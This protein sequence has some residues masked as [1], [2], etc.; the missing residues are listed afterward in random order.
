MVAL[1]CQFS[2]LSSGPEARLR[3]ASRLSRHPSPRSAARASAGEVL[4]EVLTTS[5]RSKLD[6]SDDRRFYDVPR[7]CTHVDDA[8]ISQV[9]ELYRQR[10]PAGASVLDLGASHLSHLPE[11]VEYAVV[12]H[13]MNAQELS[14]NR[15]LSSFFVRNLNEAPRGWALADCSLD[16]VV[17]CVSVQYFQRPEEV[18]AEFWRVLKPGGI[19][20]FTFSNRMFST[21]AIATWRDGT[22][23]SRAQLVKSYFGCVAGFTQPEVLTEVS[24]RP[25]DSVLGKLKRLFARSSSD[26]FYAV[27]AYR[28]FK[29]V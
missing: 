15:R 20:I 8:F 25:D 3:L 7:L 19:A 18:F 27:I 24:T 17:C 16:A 26:P 22:G 23:Y 13:G 10:I 11:D 21:K 2:S 5:Q 12:G 9:T 29:P 6:F 4:R 28:N 14:R 1:P